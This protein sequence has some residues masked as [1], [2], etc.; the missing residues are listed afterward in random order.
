PNEGT[1]GDWQVVTPGYFETMRLRVR[2]GRVFDARDRMDAPLAMIVNRRFVEKYL[3]GREPLGVRVRI[4]NPSGP[5]YTIVGVVDDVTHNGLTTAVKPQFYATLAQF[6][7]S[8]GNTRRSMSIVVRGRDDPMALAAPV[9]AAIRSIDPRLPISEIRPMEA[10]VGTSIAE[11]R[12]AM[13]LLG[14]FG[15]LALALSAIGIFGIVSQV[16]ASRSHEFGI[17]AALGA[18]PRELILLSLRVGVRQMLVGLAVG[19]GAALALTRG[20]SALLH[21][22]AA[23][24]PGTFMGVVA[25]TA[26]VTVAAS[27]IPARRAARADPAAVLHAG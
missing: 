26:L 6:A 27:L 19:I 13:Q 12:F 11:P 16:V 3:A 14:L 24:D 25:I 1:P 5:P 2:A 4:G 10:I 20:M 9:R 18:T 17:R 15:G 8:P 21:G 7:V 22:V 23:T